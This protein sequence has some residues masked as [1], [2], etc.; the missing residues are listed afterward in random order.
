MD[1][2]TTKEDTIDQECILLTPDPEPPREIAGVVQAIL[3]AYHQQ[4]G[5]NY[6]EGANLPSQQH[7]IDIT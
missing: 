6:A 2:E 7:I 1:S 5:I 3:D 4:G